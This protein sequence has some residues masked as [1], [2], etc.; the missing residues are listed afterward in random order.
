MSHLVAVLTVTLVLQTDPPA[1]PGPPPDPLSALQTTII[2]AIATAEPSVVTITR[3]RSGDGTTQAVAGRGERSVNDPLVVGRDELASPEFLPMPGDFGSGVV[4]G[5]EGQIL[6]TFHLVRGSAR[7]FVRA[8]GGVAFDAQILAADPRSDLAVL[9]PRPSLDDRPPPALTSLLLG[10]ADALRKGSFLIALGNPYNAAR[11]GSGTPRTEVFVHRFPEPDAAPSGTIELT[12][13]TTPLSYAGAPHDCEAIFVD[14]AG[15]LFLLSK[16][17]EGA[18]TLYRAAAPD[19]TPVAV[20][21]P[22]PLT[23]PTGR[24]ASSASRERV[25]C[26]SRAACARKAPARSSASRASFSSSCV[27]NPSR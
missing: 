12:A 21:P 22:P 20:A 9:V 26:R 8:P 17:D 16:H 1:A 25:T 11:D 4:I 5:P 19:A 6:T 27:D 14:P 23:A 15:D 3:V 7:I 24:S 2:E 13:T 18:S 10:D